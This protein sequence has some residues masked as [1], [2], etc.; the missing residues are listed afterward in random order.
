[1]KPLSGIENMKTKNTRRGTKKVSGL[2]SGSTTV[3][4]VNPQR[5]FVV[6]EYYNDIISL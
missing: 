5:T 1:M 4:P 6:S 3:N 2:R